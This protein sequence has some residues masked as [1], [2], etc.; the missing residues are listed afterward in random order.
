MG[1]GFRGRSAHSFP[2]HGQLRP[3]QAENAQLKREVAKLKAERDIPKSRGLLRVGEPMKFA[4]ISK[5]R[6]SAG[7]MEWGHSESRA[8]ASTPG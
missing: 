5:Y 7:E 1:Q 3:E 8:V 6:E 4:F 2:S